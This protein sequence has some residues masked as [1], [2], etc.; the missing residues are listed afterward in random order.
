MS[1][2]ASTASLLSSASTEPEHLVPKLLSSESTLVRSRRD[3]RRIDWVRCRAANESD[4]AQWG[5]AVV[6]GEYLFFRLRRATGLNMYLPR[7]E[8][9]K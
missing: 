2:E 4:R 7:G 6:I 8:M 9:A 3:E 1:S 5:C